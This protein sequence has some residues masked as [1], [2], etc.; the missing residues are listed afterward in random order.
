MI[1]D[2]HNFCLSIC[3]SKQTS[4][5]ISPKIT[6]NASKLVTLVVKTCDVVLVWSNANSSA[7]PA[8]I[9]STTDLIVIMAKT[10]RHLSYCTSPELSLYDNRLK[11]QPPPSKTVSWLLILICLSTH[12]LCTDLY[13]FI[14][15]HILPAFYEAHV[16]IS[17]YLS[18]YASAV[19]LLSNT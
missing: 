11:I 9:C 2:P 5:R 18:L 10:V 3:S 6:K 15:S 12:N 19:Q 13:T 1:R 16:Y 4:E 14:D 8:T 7:H 17:V